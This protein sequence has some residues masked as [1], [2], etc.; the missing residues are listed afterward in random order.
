MEFE[1]EKFWVPVKKLDLAAKLPTKAHEWDA[2]WDLYACGDY[3]L[4]GM[5]NGGGA[6]RKLIDTGISMAI[7]NG[8]VGLVWPKSG[9]AT[10][11][12]IDVLAGVIDAEYRGE[13]QVA[14]INHGA[15][16]I[17]INSGKKVAQ[18]VIQPIMSCDMYEVLEL[19]ETTRGDGGFGSTG[20]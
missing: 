7:P 2:G 8:Y 20:A 14:L 11:Y 18:L 6:Q 3:H 15:N 5:K 19:D 13:I 10:V 17:W 4:R 12:G 9:L 1:Q 16:D